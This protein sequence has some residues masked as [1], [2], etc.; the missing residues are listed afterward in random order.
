MPL[1]KTDGQQVAKNITGTALIKDGQGRVVMA[2]EITAAADI[3][4]HDCATTGAVA[5][6]NMIA[7]LPNAVGVY[8][9]N[10]P[11]MLGLVVVAGA[12]VVSVSYN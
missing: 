7:K 12:G 3:A 10:M 9:V 8:E 1:D 6:S 4:F 11:F 2:S 5:A